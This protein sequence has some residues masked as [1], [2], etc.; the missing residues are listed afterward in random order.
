MKRLFLTTSIV[1]IGAISA[2]LGHAQ[3][4]STLSSSD[5]VHVNAAVQTTAQAIGL[6]TG[7]FQVTT[8]SAQPNMMYR[9]EGA[10]LMTTIMLLR[11]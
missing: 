6:H 2:G 10:S 3:E 5:Y 7:D 4:A 8:R 9:G 11:D 1:A